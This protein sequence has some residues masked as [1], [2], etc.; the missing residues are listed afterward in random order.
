M[1]PSRTARTIC[2]CNRNY[3]GPRRRWNLSQARTRRRS[4]G[5]RST[6]RFLER[7]NPIA[8]AN[9]LA[10]RDLIV[11]P[12]HDPRDPEQPPIHVAFARAA[13]LNRGIQMALVGGI[14]S[15]KTTELRL[16][17]RL[18][19]RHADAM[20]VFLDLADYADLNSLNSGGIVGAIGMALFSR[21]KK[22]GLRPSDDVKSAH[23]LLR[24]R[25]VGTWVP[26]GE[27]LPEDEEDPSERPIHVPGLLRLQVS[28]D[29]VP[30]PESQRA[31]WT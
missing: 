16:T 28:C 17:E 3:T 26:A 15:G 7:L 18:L 12:E 24:K 10:E 2:R 1:G 25:T 21:Y 22:A 30:G 11:T 9:T 23:D 20:T 27:W 4:T 31:C 19:N 5:A 8:S 6:G 29:S 14:G 13:E